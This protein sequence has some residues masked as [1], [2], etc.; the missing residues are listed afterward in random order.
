MTPRIFAL[1]VAIAI[2]AVLLVAACS[3]GTKAAPPSAPPA[4]GP[5]ISITDMKFS[6]PPP[7]PPGAKVTVTNSDGVEHT[8]TADSGSA[9]NVEVDEKGT[10][11]F[12]APSQPGT[13]AYH[14][15][16]HPTMHGQ[17]IVQ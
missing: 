9:F 4:P 10:A 8:V 16:Y 11:T 6:S 12:T 17:L 15:N 7:V 3:A 5:T 14:C 1:S 2:A 13:Y